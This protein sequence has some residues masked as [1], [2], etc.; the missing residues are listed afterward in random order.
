M[1]T[2]FSSGRWGY[3]YPSK[4]T[5][6]G[7]EEE[8]TVAFIHFKLTFQSVCHNFLT[9]EGVAISISA[10]TRVKLKLFIVIK[11]LF[12]VAKFAAHWNSSLSFSV[13]LKVD[14][15]VGPC[16]FSLSGA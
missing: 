8:V 13:I 12:V 2:T 14:G 10:S 6:P 16:I 5:A 3:T 7:T 9:P 11:M 15:S 4:T 1:G